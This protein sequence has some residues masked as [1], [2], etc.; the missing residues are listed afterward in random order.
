[1][2]TI[3][4]SIQERKFTFLE[5]QSDRITVWKAVI[6]CQEMVLIYDTARHVITSALTLEMWEFNKGSRENFW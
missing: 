3:I 2:T 1:M 6:Q 4:R 5:R